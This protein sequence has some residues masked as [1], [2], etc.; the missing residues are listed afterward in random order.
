MKESR[1]HEP[2]LSGVYFDENSFIHDDSF[3]H[4][5]YSNKSEQHFVNYWEEQILKQGVFSDFSSVSCV[6]NY[7]PVNTTYSEIFSDLKFLTQ[8]D[9][10]DCANEF[11]P[12][13]QE[14]LHNNNYLIKICIIMVTKSQENCCS[15]ITV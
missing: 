1:N 7:T 10:V 14:K 8:H 15:N 5:S 2:L 11:S 6:G 12:L 3:L 13:S 9:M 4:Q